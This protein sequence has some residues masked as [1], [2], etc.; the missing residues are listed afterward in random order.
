MTMKIIV[1]WDVMLCCLSPSSGQ[2]LEIEDAGSSNYP[3]ILYG[4]PQHRDLWNV[5]LLVSFLQHGKGHCQLVW[6]CI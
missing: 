3:T 4:L 2:A 1:S 6:N 5:I